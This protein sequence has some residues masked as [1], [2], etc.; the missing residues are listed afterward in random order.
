MQDVLQ[1]DTELNLDM[2]LGDLEEW[3]SLSIMATMA[4]IDKNFGV[5][6]RV[7]DIKAMKTIGDLAKKAGI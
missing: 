2:V 4:F 3:D 7:A 6:L 5:K 1:T